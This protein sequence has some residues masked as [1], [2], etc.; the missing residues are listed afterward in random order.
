MM[1]IFGKFVDNAQQG[2]VSYTPG[3]CA[4]IQKD[5]NRP[6]NWR[7]RDLMESDQQKYKILHPG[8]NNPRH[9]H[10]LGINSLER[11]FAKKVLMVLVDN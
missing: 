5:L 11:I 8:W 6:K 7:E 10:T 3:G 4:T 1:C 2:R 9:H